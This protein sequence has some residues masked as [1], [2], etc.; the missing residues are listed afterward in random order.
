MVRLLQMKISMIEQ[1]KSTQQDN[2]IQSLSMIIS[3]LSK[4]L[5]PIIES[6]YYQ[7]EAAW[8]VSQ[9][10]RYLIQKHKSLSPEWYL[11]SYNSL[12]PSIKLFRSL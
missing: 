11:L 10:K 6:E 2:R 9:H 1:A 8:N 12:I 7:E 3:I 4:H 5:N